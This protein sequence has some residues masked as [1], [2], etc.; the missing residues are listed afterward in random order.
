M[1]L[2]K[3]S[4][5]VEFDTSVIS[6]GC[7]IYAKHNSWSEGKT[8]FVTSVRSEEITVQYHPGI[9]NVT[10]HFFIKAADVEAGSWLVRW[11][12]DLREVYEYPAQNTEPDEEGSE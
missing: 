7:A 11:T 5:K 4:S 2:I 3:E 8:G 1:E 12:K 10:N 9:G 6:L